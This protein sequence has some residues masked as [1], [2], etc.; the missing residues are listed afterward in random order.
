MKSNLYTATRPF[1]NLIQI[2]CAACGALGFLLCL[3]RDETGVLQ[4]VGAFLICAGL[5]AA[6]ENHQEK[7]RIKKELRRS[8]ERRA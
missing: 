7:A 4:N 2:V 5:G 6:I 3:A 8:S 1:Y